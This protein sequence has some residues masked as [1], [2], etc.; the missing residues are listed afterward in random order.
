MLQWQKEYARPKK[1][2]SA[3]KKKGVA[4]EPVVIKWPRDRPDMV[5]KSLEPE[6]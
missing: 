1:A 4:V 5:G 3:L 6:P 2:A